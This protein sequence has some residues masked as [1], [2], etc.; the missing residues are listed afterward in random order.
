MSKVFFYL[1]TFLIYKHFDVNKRTARLSANIPLI[2][3]NF[4]PLSF[5]DFP[6][7]DYTSAVIAIYELQDIRPLLDLYL[8]SYERTCDMYDSTVKSL[9][10]DEV[11]VRYR[12]QR[13]DV[14]RTIILNRLF[15]KSMKEYIANQT[16]KLTQ[17]E[18]QKSFFEDIMEDLKEI[19]LNRIVG[20][21][22]TPNH[23][24]A[25]LASINASF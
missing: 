17:K 8:F 20:L 18:D 3:K 14:I 7:D 19:N 1:H 23:L 9:G 22:I 15:G 21:G 16:L 25:W 11:R 10:F 6:R 2:K 24:N 4:V 13:R 5:N 12:Q